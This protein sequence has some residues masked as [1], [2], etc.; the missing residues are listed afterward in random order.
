MSVPLTASSYW[1]WVPSLLSYQ[2]WQPTIPPFNICSTDSTEIFKSKP[3]D[4]KL[5]IK[6]VWLPP[7]GS[8]PKEFSWRLIA[9]QAQ[10][11]SQFSAR[12]CQTNL[13]PPQLR[14][15]NDFK[16]NHSIITVNADKGRGIARIE[17]EQ[18]IRDAF[19]FHFNDRSTYKYF[20]ADEAAEEANLIR[21][22]IDEWLM[23]HEV[24]LGRK[25]CQYIRHHVGDC[26][27]P[28]PFFYQLYKIHKQPVKTQPV[29]SGYGSLLHS[30]GHW[31]DEQLQCCQYGRGKVLLV[32][33]ND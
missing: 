11:S 12:K 8:F 10:V 13:S 9:F 3:G 24:L 19:K 1:D 2:K 14:L 5:F 27:Q 7:E 31:I 28:V 33:L 32:D 21:N 6:S 26:S 15:L 23:R 20:S 30:I 16:Q 4:P 18:Y 17:Y 22:K 29:I 25:E